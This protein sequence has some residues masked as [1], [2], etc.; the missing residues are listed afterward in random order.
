MSQNR[1][2]IGYR[3]RLQQRRLGGESMRPFEDR[4]IAGVVVLAATALSTAAHA[5]APTTV[6]FPAD[7]NGQITF[8]MPSQNVECTY[9]PAGGTPIYKPFDGGPEL[10]CDRRDPTYVRLIMTPK[11]VKKI[12]DV[13]DQG[14]C[15]ASNVFAYGKRWTM[16][17]FTCD[18]A[19]TGLTCKRTDGR[20]FTASR[21]SASVF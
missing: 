10:S 21:E 6:N 5:Q 14:C 17:P 16:G 7:K 3:H 1:A 12:D 15:G 4:I 9:T 20:G 8:V 19:A 11:S 13:G 2:N 18:S